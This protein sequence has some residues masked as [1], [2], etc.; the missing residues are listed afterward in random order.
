MG[1]QAAGVRG[2]RLAKDDLVVGMQAV[3]NDR[4]LVFATEQGFGK[5]VKVNDFRIAHRGGSGVRTIPTNDRNGKVI[6]LGIVDDENDMLLIDQQGKIIRL[7]ST[8][9]RTMGRQAQGVRLIRL[10]QGQKLVRLAIISC[11]EQNDAQERKSQCSQTDDSCIVLD[12]EQIDEIVD[13][14]SDDIVVNDD[15]NETNETKDIDE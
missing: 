13:T 9:I 5:R 14:V 10:D 4:D 11:C 2:I 3:S 15:S 1:R 8:E 6:G 12:D 7:P